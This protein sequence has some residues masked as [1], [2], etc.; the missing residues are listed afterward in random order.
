MSGGTKPRVKRKQN[1]R[2]DGLSTAL[3]YNTRLK[4][5]ELDRV[6]IPCKLAVDAFRTG[7]GTFKHW[8]ILCTAGHV[9]EAIEDGRV[10]C[11]Q[12]EIID[13]ANTAL[14]SIGARAGRSEAAWKPPTL[15]AS[16]IIA[17][18]DLYAAHS[19]QVHE[20]TYGEYTAAYQKAIART[21]TAGGQAFEASYC[22][23]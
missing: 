13:D 7:H 18:N 12:R 9:A 20:L 8:V 23:S 1:S 6:L 22:Y 16:E 5:R 15:R 3:A 14:D 17:L 2:A 11:G 10:I 4:Q 21:R 19:R